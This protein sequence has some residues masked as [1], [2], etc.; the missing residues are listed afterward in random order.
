MVLTATYCKVS[1][2]LFFLGLLSL[3]DVPRP[4]LPP[5]IVN[6]D[7]TSMCAL[8]SEVCHGG[9]ENDAVCEWAQRVC[10]WEECLQVGRI[11]TALV[12]CGCRR[13]FSLYVQFVPLN[14]T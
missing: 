5:V 11:C 12:S 1:K 8:V 7:V 6:L 9:P 14:I 3:R 10:H 2:T 4:P 13:C